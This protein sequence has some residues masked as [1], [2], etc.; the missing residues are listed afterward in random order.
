M[1]EAGM[2]SN[3]K[4]LIIGELKDMKEQNI[5]FGK[6]TDEIVMDVCGELEIPIISN[7]PCGHGK[8]Q[9]TLPLSTVVKLEANSVSPTLTFL[10][11]FVN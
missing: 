2:F 7:F 4:G 5:A 9:V 11:S 1:K 10:N 6:S 8:Y 3:I